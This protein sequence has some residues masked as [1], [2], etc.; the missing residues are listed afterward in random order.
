MARLLDQI[1]V[2]DVEST[3]WEGTPP[4][5][6]FSEIIQIGICPVDVAE[7]RKIGKHNIFVRPIRSEVSPFCTALT[8]LTPEIVNAG[9]TLADAART[10]RNEFAS[11]ERLWASWGD[12]DRRQFERVCAA[13]KVGYPFGSSHLNVKTLFAVT[14]SLDSEIGMDAAL[15]M[16]DLPLE[17]I[18]HR[19]DD[20]AWNI[21]AILISLLK[22]M[23]QPPSGL[24]NSI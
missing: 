21:A 15:R 22:T 24:G 10:L 19:G 17:G 12:Y 6:Q 18:H 4:P 3:C 23:R 7:L 5:N 9:V 16:L 2:I 20:D 14:R 8:G 1:L 13:L 11:Q